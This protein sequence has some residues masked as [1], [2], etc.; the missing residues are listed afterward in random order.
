MSI[1]IE[2]TGRLLHPIDQI[3]EIL[4]GLTVAITIVRSLSIA[5]AGQT[6]VRTTTLSAL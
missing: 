2:E 6:R 4:F 5:T 1:A 3:S